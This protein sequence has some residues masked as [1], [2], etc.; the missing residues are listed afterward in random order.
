MS[1]VINSQVQMTPKERFSSIIDSFISTTT[2]ELNEAYTQ[3]GKSI[4]S[5][6][7]KETIG[8]FGNKCSNLE[9]QIKAFELVKGLITTE[10]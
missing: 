2:E 1:T 6:A 3:F 5:D 7:E 9:G 8:E 4:K 10:L